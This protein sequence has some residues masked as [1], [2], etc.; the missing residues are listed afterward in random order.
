MKGI[1]LVVSTR[2]D[3]I[4]IS[5]LI[6]EMEKR[7]LPFKILYTGQHKDFNMFGTFSRQFGVEDIL[8]QKRISEPYYPLVGVYGDT[9]SCFQQAYNYKRARREVLHIEAGLRCYDQFMFEEINRVLTDRI[10][11]YFFCP[12]VESVHNLVR[13]NLNGKAFLTGNLINDALNFIL[14]S[15][16][17]DKRKD[18]ANILITIHRRENILDD[19]FPILLDQ[20]HEIQKKYSTIFPIHPHTKKVFPKGYEFIKTCDPLDYVYFIRQLAGSKLVITDSGGVLE[21][22]CLLKTKCVVVRTCTERPEAMSRNGT[23][24]I[25]YRHLC[26]KVK[27]IMKTTLPEYSNPYKSPFDGKTVAETMCDILDM[28]IC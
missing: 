20:I 23:L 10:S 9:D 19:D 7:K 26:D 6:L 1:D 3:I 8:N 2:P 22:C 17:P 15:I 28:N 11:N 27:S 12:T 24:C 25:N 14:P 16:P 5:P 13:D 18:E 21:E 4:K